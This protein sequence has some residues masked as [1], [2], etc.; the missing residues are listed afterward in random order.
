[1]ALLIWVTAAHTDRG[2]GYMRRLIPLANS[3][4][5]GSVGASFYAQNTYWFSNIFQSVMPSVPTD[6]PMLSTEWT[7]S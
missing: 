4:F 2:E 3:R 6:R 7:G 1:M 5:A